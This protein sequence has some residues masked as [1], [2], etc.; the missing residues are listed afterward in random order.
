MCVMQEDVFDA[1]A[2]TP[3]GSSWACN[4]S[5]MLKSREE[6]GNCKEKE[7]GREWISVIT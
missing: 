4:I 5:R 3:R 1:K 7:V 2:E 6:K